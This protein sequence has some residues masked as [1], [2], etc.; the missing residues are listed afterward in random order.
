MF[1]KTI[2]ALDSLIQKL[3]RVFV[4]IAGTLT[5]L[6]IVTT[7]YGVV[8]RYF[9]RRPEPVSYEL[10]TIFLLWGFLFAVSSVEQLNQ[11]IRA[12]IFIQ[13]A[14]E[15]VRRFLHS[16]IGPF[17]ALFYCIVLTWKGWDVAIYS[18]SVGERSLSIWREPIGPIKIVIPICYG[19]LTL[20]VF[21]NLCRGLVSYLG[22]DKGK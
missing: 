16:L 21:S 17:L 22:R 4:V 15:S 5:L 9:F 11:H 1:L 12:E 6:M 8:A 18:L 7:V 14:P 10:G 20:V 3:T 13:F 19:L 2:H